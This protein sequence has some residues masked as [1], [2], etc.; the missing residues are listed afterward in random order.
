MLAATGYIAGAIGQQPD[1]FMTGINVV[2][3]MVPFIATILYMV[4]IQFYPEKELRG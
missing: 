4:L 1:S 3:F 2:R